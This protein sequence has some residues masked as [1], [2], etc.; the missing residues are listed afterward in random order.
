M[1]EEDDAIHGDAIAP[2][3]SLIAYAS[4][5]LH[6]NGYTLA[7]RVLLDVMGLSLHA[8]VPGTETLL[9][10]ALLA[11]HR[12]YAAAIRPYCGP[13]T[14]WRTSPAAGSAATWCGCCR[15]VAKP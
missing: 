3:D 12:S 5:G 14:A 9:V 11:V 1:V 8:L 15:R 7:R 4:T 2:G 10:D 6:T 13:S